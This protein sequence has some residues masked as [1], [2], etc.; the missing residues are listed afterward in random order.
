MNT[1]ANILSYGYPYIVVRAKVNGTHRRVRYY[2]RTDRAVW[3][4]P[5]T[6]DYIPGRL[7]NDDS[8]YTFIPNKG[9]RRLVKNY[10]PTNYTYA[11]DLGYR[12]KEKIGKMKHKIMRALDAA[13]K[14]R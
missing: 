14:G 11:F 6:K 9:Y 3:T 13:N 5:M 7:V 8:G 10:V 4:H 12:E 2:A 1:Q